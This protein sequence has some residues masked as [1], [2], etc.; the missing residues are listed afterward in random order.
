M[1]TKTD[2]KAKPQQTLRK[3]HSSNTLPPTRVPI[4]P[5]RVYK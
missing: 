1:A 2:T 4:Q 3:E 5:F